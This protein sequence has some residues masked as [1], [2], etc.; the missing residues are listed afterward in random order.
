MSTRDHC[1]R[2][3]HALTASSEGSIIR[4]GNATRV[5]SSGAASPRKRRL[6]NAVAQLIEHLTTDQKGGSSVSTGALCCP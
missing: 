2:L 4:L 6:V 5:R 1:A 3:R